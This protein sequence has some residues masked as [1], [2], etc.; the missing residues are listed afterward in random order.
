MNGLTSLSVLRVFFAWGFIDLILSIDNTDAIEMWLL[1]E[2]MPCT[3]SS[4]FHGQ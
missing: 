3:L 2:D 4:I 1:W